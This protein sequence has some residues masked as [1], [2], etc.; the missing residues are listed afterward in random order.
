MTPASLRRLADDLRGPPRPGEN[1]R[2][3]EALEAAAA[4]LERAAELRGTAEGVVRAYGDAGGQRPPVIEA[5]AEVLHGH[6]RA[7]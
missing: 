3:A 6:R 2:A 4:A 1:L 5:L 7:V